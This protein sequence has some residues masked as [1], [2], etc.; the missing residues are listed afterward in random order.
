MGKIQWTDLPR[1][2]RQHLFDRLEE[3]RITVEDLYKLKLW[4][5]SEPEAPDGPWC[6]DFGSFKICGES[7]FPKT[8]LL[9]GQPARGKSLSTSRCGPTH[10]WRPAMLSRE[11]RGLPDMAFSH[12]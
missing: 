7:E 10:C 1:A 8:L 11:I 9:K 6:R 5:E 4:R 3:R 12:S 2:I